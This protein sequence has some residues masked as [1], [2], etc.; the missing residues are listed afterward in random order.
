MSA[1]HVRRGDSSGIFQPICVLAAAPDAD[2][3]LAEGLTL[4]WPD[5]Q[6]VWRARSEGGQQFTPVVLHENAGE[7]E[8]AAAFASAYPALIVGADGRP[9]GMARAAA[10][11]AYVLRERNRA[12]ALID[13]VL[14]TAD[15]LICGI[16]EHGVVTMFN[17][18]AE[19]LYKIK[20]E[21]IVGK[22]ITDFFSDLVITK[23]QHNAITSGQV[24]RDQYHQPVLG[25]HVL[26]NA[27]P[28]LMQ[29]RVIGA[30]T[31]EREIT[32]TM[33]LSNEL[34][35][36]NTQVSNLQREIMK[37][38]RPTDAFGKIY[39]QS[40]ALTSVVEMAKRVA[41]TDVSILL[42]GESG[43]GKELFAEAIHRASSRHDKPFVIINCGA[44]PFNLFESELFGYLPG[45]FTGADR[46]GRKGKFDEANHG[47]LF[48][49]E[50]GELPLDMQVKLLRVLQNQ[51]FYRVGGGDPIA[52]DVRVI[53]ATNRPLE[54]MIEE[55]LFRD[56]LYY[57]INVVS[58]EIPPLRERKED[59]SQLVRL[60]VRECCMK[61]GIPAKHI[62]PEVIEAMRRYSWPGNIRELRNVA[63]RM[64]VL[65]ESGSITADNLPSLIKYENDS[66]GL[67]D[68]FG[69]LLDITDK[70][71]RDLIMQAL[72]KCGNDRSR[73]AKLLGIPRS[74]LYY[75][76]NKYGMQ[77]KNIKMSKKST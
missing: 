1:N 76:L 60:F 27:G 67:G 52:V 13:A 9:R 50:I 6:R 4:I 11:C 77:G 62:E 59:I 53:S 20:R 5:E 21:E 75:K 71:E 72:D 63:E 54:K 33:R 36:S 43:T 61:Q 3:P 57:R 32:E 28:V 29:N 19:Q 25:A 7:A 35:R 12:I 55:G 64:V 18:R 10:Y 17:A 14:D 37:I 30:V 65:S 49:D 73:A 42:R 26:C 15:E 47:T 68:E 74:T 45:S 41:H 66:N 2:M 24:V 46:R 38:N 39:G 69:C 22:P 8:L 48:L 56:D 58:L 23:V 31:A 70:T 51:R 44:I 34:A 40:P 16:D